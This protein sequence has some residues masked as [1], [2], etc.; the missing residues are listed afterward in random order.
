MAITLHGHHT[1]HHHHH[2][3][4]PSVF[5]SRALDPDVHWS[6]THSSPAHQTKQNERSTEG[7]KEKWCEHEA[8][9]LRDARC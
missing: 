8:P 7:N 4:P 5:F 2:H 6:G 1:N 3:G 9:R